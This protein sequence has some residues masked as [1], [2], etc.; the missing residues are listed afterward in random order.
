M[1]M[2]FGFGEENGHLFVYNI[3]LSPKQRMMLFAQDVPT[4]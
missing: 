2:T 4:S 3:T 1:E